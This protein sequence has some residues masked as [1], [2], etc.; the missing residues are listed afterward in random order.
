MNQDAEHL[1]KVIAVLLEHLDGQIV[2]SNEEIE[3][4]PDVEIRALFE[5]DEIEMRVSRK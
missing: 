5:T 1:S 4:A 3:D 2:L